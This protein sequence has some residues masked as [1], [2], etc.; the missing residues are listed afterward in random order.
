M[1]NGEQIPSPPSRRRRGLKSSKAIPSNVGQT[2][3]RPI[4]Q[5]ELEIFNSL[6]VGIAV[7]TPALQFL[8]A[9]PAFCFLSGHSEKELR[10]L[11]W[12]DLLPP[13]DWPG[14]YRQIDPVLSGQVS[15][16][17]IEVPYLR[18]DGETV[19]VRSRVTGHQEY[20]LLECQPETNRSSTGA[21]GAA[22]PQTV[23]LK[24]TDWQLLQKLSLEPFTDNEGDPLLKDI[25]DAAK[26]ITGSDRASL[27]RLHPER[28]QYGELELVHTIDFT[29][30][31]ADIFQWVK[32]TTG[33]VC[34][35]AFR[36]KSRIVVEDIDTCP[37]LDSSSLAALRTSDIRAVQ[38]TPLLSRSGQLIGMFST[39]W[40]H[41]HRLTLWEEGVCDILA[42][43]MADL[44]ERT[45]AETAR[46][47]SEERFRKLF[48]L[49]GSG[50][51]I[52]DLD[53]QIQSC[54]PVFCTLLGYTEEELYATNCPSLVHPE[55]VEAYL[56]AIQ[57]LKRQE[58]PF[59]ELE[60]RYLHKNGQPIFVRKYVSILP[61]LQGPPQLII[62][63]L[64]ITDRKHTE[65]QLRRLKD[66]LQ[67]KVKQRTRKLMDSQ[68]RLRALAHQLTLTEERE[69]RK[70]ATD[71]HDYLAQLLVVGAMK[72]D[73]IK[74]GKPSPRQTEESLQELHDILQQALTY[75]RTTIAELM[76]PGLQESGLFSALQWLGE[77]MD[78]H[79]LQVEIQTPPQ[80]LPLS[81]EAATLLFQSVRELLF[82]VL[83]HAGVDQAV[84]RVATE[85][86]GHLCL[87]VE[88]AG[89]GMDV[90]AVVHSHIPG[91][92]G[93]FAIQERMQALGG[94]VT[95]Q[96]R[97]SEGTLVQL[98]LPLHRTH[99]SD[100]DS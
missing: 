72:L 80:E 84:V 17:L 50:I 95:F 89:K 28:G 8:H 44:L 35:E 31:T 25:L 62:F 18:P 76:P 33:C 83:R 26:T 4:F 99:Q 43:Q 87:S 19:I 88:D 66:Q 34:G 64:D 51:T 91:H 69:R 37:F 58:C 21:V 56:A 7:L 45:Q 68:E 79:G 60:H 86:E 15:E 39:H 53:G 96:S 48:Y 20:V 59:I 27:Q 90:D 6:S 74:H 42:R 24:L 82:N 63:A 36:T 46:R 73:Q 100:Q 22:G 13:Q 47:V 14:F 40:R 65:D 23:T 11:N 81:E 70:L 93:L 49:A 9:N 29:P 71:L 61:N 57:R 3:K 5:R 55:D 16:C 32:L 85:P 41:P 92:L 67:E 30:K 78:K 98:I 94:R 54:N 10:R 75:T 52:T 1:N 77:A 38:T 12:A 97:L 2:R